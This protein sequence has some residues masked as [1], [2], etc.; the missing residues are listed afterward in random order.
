MLSG[1]RESAL[2][3][4]C[5]TFAELGK[6]SPPRRQYPFSGQAGECP[7]CDGPLDA[8]F[9]DNGVGMQQVTPAECER[10]SAYQDYEHGWHPGEALVLHRKG[11]TRDRRSRRYRHARKKYWVR[12]GAY[13]RAKFDCYRVFLGSQKLQGVRASS[14][15]DEAV[16]NNDWVDALQYAFKGKTGG[17]RVA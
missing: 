13:D 8:E 7:Y 17:I 14:V 6:R 2:V 12:W 5:S 1:R 15:I 16:R 10:C 11:T 9:V 4:A 3:L